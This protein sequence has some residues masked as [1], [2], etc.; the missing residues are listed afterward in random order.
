VHSLFKNAKK[1]I[2]SSEIES[3]QYYDVFQDLDKEKIVKIPNGI[4][5]DQYTNLPEY[6]IFRKKYSIGDN[7]IILFIGRLH[8]RKGADILIKAF[9]RLKYDINDLKLIIAGP[10]DSYLN[11]LKN[12]VKKFNIQKDVIFPGPLY[13]RDKL[14]AYVSADVFVLPSKDKYESFGN[15]VLEASACGTTSVVTNVCGVTEYVKNIILVNPSVKS[16]EIGLRKGLRE[17]NLG[18][19]A[20]IEVKRKC[21]WDKVCDKYIDTYRN[22]VNRG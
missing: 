17:D 18:K 6:T 4:N 19:K 11:V 2:A 16:I 15:V 21:G 14:E 22:I 13:N 9:S 20:R 7:R 1:I 5:W 12:R 3:K 8:E 10:N